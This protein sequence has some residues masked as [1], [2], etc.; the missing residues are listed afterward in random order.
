MRIVRNQLIRQYKGRFS[1]K[2]MHKHTCNGYKTHA[3]HER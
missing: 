1:S 2:Y 3:K